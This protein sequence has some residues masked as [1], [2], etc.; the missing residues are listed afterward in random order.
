MNTCSNEI[1]KGYKVDTPGTTAT[2]VPLTSGDS[3]SILT[4]FNETDKPIKIAYKNEGGQ[5]A[6]FYVP[7]ARSFTRVVNGSL[8]LN[9]LSVQA[10]GAVATGSVYFNLG[11]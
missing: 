10:I 5:A 2:N 6:N 7:P 3:Y 8:M 1:V 4:V 9:S 11:N